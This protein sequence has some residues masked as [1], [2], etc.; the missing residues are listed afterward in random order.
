MAL[1]LFMLVIYI[2]CS[3]NIYVTLLESG[4]ILHFCTTWMNV[5]LNCSV[6][7]LD[8]LCL[9]TIFH[10][11]KFN[12]AMI[13]IEE[14]PSLLPLLCLSDPLLPPLAP[15]PEAVQ[16]V[17]LTPSWTK[18]PGWPHGGGLILILILILRSVIWPRWVC[19]V[20]CFHSELTRISIFDNCVNVIIPIKI[21]D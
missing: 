9:W 15:P 19:L 14:N 17:R 13:I 21:M 2:D 18:R 12:N 16:E 4:E 7:Y 6:L 8:I 3:S 10:N 1:R 5:K 20:W 11:N